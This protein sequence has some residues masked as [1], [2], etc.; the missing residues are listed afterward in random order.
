MKSGM[1]EYWCHN[2]TTPKQVAGVVGGWRYAFLETE[3]TATCVA[4]F[5]RRISMNYCRI[6]KIES[7]INKRTS[8]DETR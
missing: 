6:D 4:I 5:E 2:I 3:L 8:V 7:V 1:L